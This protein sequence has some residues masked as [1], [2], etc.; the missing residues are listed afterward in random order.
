MSKAKFMKSFSKKYCIIA[1]FNI[2][3]IFCYYNVEVVAQEYFLGIEEG[4]EFIYE[5]EELNAT[6]FAE[7]LGFEPNF[8]ER[9]L[10]KVLILDISDYGNY[11]RVNIEFWDYGT[12]FNDNGSIQNIQI[13]KNPIQYRHCIFLPIP[14]EDYLQEVEDLY[15][16]D[17]Y[18][19][20]SSIFQ[21]M[22]SEI[23]KTYIHQREYD[24]NGVLRTEIIFDDNDNV[25]MKLRVLEIKLTIIRPT[26]SDMLYSKE[27]FT[28]RW[29]TSGPVQKVKLE[30]HHYLYGFL[31]QLTNTFTENDGNFNWDIGEYLGDK[32]II[33]IIDYDHPYFNNVSDIFS[34]KKSSSFLDILGFPLITIF[35]I[36]SIFCV[37]ILITRERKLKFS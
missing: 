19:V 30:L 33:K 2:L 28:I 32:F 8:G 36:L 6:L 17:Y 26:S 25:F 9:D 37:V 18:C 21:Q 1:F 23:N 29:N 13:Y 20:G 22:K 15:S 11:W 27:N 16:L 35:G 4:D 34:I 3:L 31:E 12:D 7:V 14:I 5:V 24:A 10:L